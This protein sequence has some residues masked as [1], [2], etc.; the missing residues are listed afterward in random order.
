[1]SHAQKHPCSRCIEAEVFWM[2][3]AKQ[4]EFA[5]FLNSTLKKSWTE[6]A[7][8]AKVQPVPPVGD[9]GVLDSGYD[10]EIFR[11]E[12]NTGLRYSKSVLKDFPD[13][14]K[15][16]GD[17]RQ[18]VDIEI[19]KATKH[20]KQEMNGAIAYTIAKNQ[21][22]RFLRNQ[23][24]EQTVTLENLDGTPVLDEFG[25]PRKISRHI[26]LDDRGFEEDGAARETSLVEETIA[27]SGE[28]EKKAWMDDIRRKMPLLEKLVSGWFGAKRTIGEALLE[29]PEA[30]VRDFPGVPKS[31][32][33]RIRQAVLKEFQ[34]ALGREW[35]KPAASAT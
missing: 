6:I 15:G 26:S 27:T 3:M 7:V 10:T 5:A 1:M 33:H 8:K 9:W 16:F 18:I 23:I 30:T 21:A 20:Y 11:K 34:L 2:G 32:A 12:I 28:E 22:G 24:N 17:L 4:A 35:D 19:W 31:T 29:N 13:S 25:E 14:W